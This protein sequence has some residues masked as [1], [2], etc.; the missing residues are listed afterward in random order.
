MYSLRDLIDEISQSDLAQAYL[1]SDKPETKA[2]P[3]AYLSSLSLARRELYI[4][5]IYS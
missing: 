5:T 2:I 1:L 3:V 4:S